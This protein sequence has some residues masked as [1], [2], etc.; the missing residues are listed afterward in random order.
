MVYAKHFNPKMSPQNQKTPGTKQVKNNA[1]GYVYQISNWDR[2]NR[3]LI[4]GS[5]GGSYYVSEKKLTVDNANNVIACIKEDGKRAVDAIVHVSENGLAA[6]NKPA[7]FA[8]A[9]A[10]SADNV[11]TRQYALSQLPKVARIGTHLFEFAQYVSMFRGWG[12][13]LRESISNWYLEKSPADLSYQIIKY[14][15]RTTEEGV[16]NSMWSHRDIL[17]KAHPKSQGLHNDIFNYITQGWE[18]IPTNVPEELKILVGTEFIKKA[19]SAKEAAKLIEEYNLPQEVVPK[20]FMNDPL[21]MTTLLKK[22]PLIATVRNLGKLTSLGVIKPLS[23]ELEIVL[24]RL[25]NDHII[26]KS[27]IHP[28][29]VLA[30]LKTYASGKGFKGSLSW[31]PNQKVINALNAL[32]YKSFKNIEPTGKNILIALDIS[33]SMWSPCMGMDQITAMEAGAMIA[34][35]VANTE[36]NYH[37]IGFTTNITELQISPNQRLD[38]VLNYCGKLTMGRTDCAQPM[39]YAQKN[40]LNVDTFVVITDNETWA[41]TVKPDQALRDYRKMYNKNAKLIVLATSSTQFSIANPDDPGMLD[42]CGFSSDVP[43][44]VSN[45]IRGSF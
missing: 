14:P 39:L 1:G 9:L 23:S 19:Q 38:Q 32:M 36:K 25:S 8:L 37:I 21:V 24:E 44:L 41:G 17:R 16:S 30:A 6:K 43:S 10:A 12:R 3:F 13:N 7:L 5:E 42:I 29:N 26:T 34:L 4:M 11:E 40:K 45:F 31:Q 20:E 22:M 2:L 28:I 18:E 27:K 35:A 15:Q 33:G